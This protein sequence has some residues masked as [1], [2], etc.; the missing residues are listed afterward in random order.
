M[1]G[2]G[3]RRDFYSRNFWRDGFEVSDKYLFFLDLIKSEKPKRF[4]DL[5]CGNGHFAR[6]VADALGCE[7]L[8]IDISEEGVEA[9]RRAGVQATA[10]DIDAHPLPYPAE[11]IDFVYSGEVIEHLHYPDHYL[12][13][14]R[15]VL[16]PGGKLLLTTPNLG[17]WYN[18]FSLLL[19]YQP[20]FSDVSL[21]C[22]VGHL[23]P[24][25]T[26]AHTRLFTLRALKGLLIFHGFAVSV[27]WGIPINYKCGFGKA[28]PF[29]ARVA[30]LI[31]RHPAWNSG[32]LVMARKP[33][34]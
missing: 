28:H 29:L 17:A 5:G 34:T 4:L 7:T 24:M 10:L 22:S 14:I 19:G 21:E 26:M 12:R 20:I 27:F 18:R 25:G 8:G 33:E 3:Y 9:A 32:I 23:W 31:F 16:T 1:S 30:N 11:F 13:E 2:L 15:R 6:A